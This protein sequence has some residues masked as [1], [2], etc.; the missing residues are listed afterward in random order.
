[1]CEAPRAT[2]E[3]RAWLSKECELF[4]RGLATQRCVSMWGA[5]KAVDD[6]LVS[7]FEVVVALRSTFL[8][9]TLRNLVDDPRLAVHVRHVHEDA[10]FWWEREVSFCR[11]GFLGQRQ[12]Q[13]VV[14]PS[15]RVASVHVPRELIQNDDFS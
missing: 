4:L 2:L 10:F 13:R 12:R 5:T 9:Q 14:R 7:K 6:H 15:A 11:H 8:E 1:M 3:T